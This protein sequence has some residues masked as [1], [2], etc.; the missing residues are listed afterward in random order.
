M[1]HLPT[2]YDG[3]PTTV[4]TDGAPELWSLIADLRAG[5]GVDIEH[6]RTDRVHVDERLTAVCELVKRE[7]GPRPSC[8]SPGEPALGTERIHRAR[9]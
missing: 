1:R 4:V 9:V 7:P 2:R 3:V 8:A 6:E 5:N